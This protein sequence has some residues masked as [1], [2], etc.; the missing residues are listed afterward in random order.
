MYRHLFENPCVLR[1]AGNDPL[2]PFNRIISVCSLLMHPGR[3]KVSVLDII[4]KEG[5]YILRQSAAHGNVTV[6]LA[7]AMTHKDRLALEIDIANP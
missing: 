1:C 4:A 6:F 2:Q 3:K 5:L 7:L